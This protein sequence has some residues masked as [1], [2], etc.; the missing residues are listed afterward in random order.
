MYAR[1]YL[2]VTE[3]ATSRLHSC[4]ILDYLITE[5][6]IKRK[7]RILAD[8]LKQLPQDVREDTP[9]KREGGILWASL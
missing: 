3:Q 6:T 1:T 4:N 9:F 7:L 8:A 5:V 2:V